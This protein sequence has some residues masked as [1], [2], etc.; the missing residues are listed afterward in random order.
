M[1]QGL[2]GGCFVL[3]L[4]LAGA[5][6]RAEEAPAPFQSLAFD[7]ALKRAA[8]ENKIVFVDFFTTWCGPCQMLDATTWKDPAVAALLREKTVALR[9]DAEKEAALAQ[10]YDVQ[11]YPTMALIKPDGTVIDRL[12]GYRDA[13]KFQSDFADSL[14][15]KTSLARAREEAA[16]AKGDADATAKARY[17]LGQELARAGKND[18]A[19][20]E[21]LWC[22]DDGM[23]KAVGYSGVRLSFLTSS[24][25][26]LGKTYPPALDALRQR[27]DGARQKM[28]KTPSD[29]QAAGDFAALNDAL[30]D[31]QAT[32]DYFDK[33]PPG[34]LRRAA[35]GY[36]LF[37]LLIDAK[38]YAD[39]AAAVPYDQ[40][41][42]TFLRLITPRDGVSAEATAALH[43]YS[44]GY[45]A[46][47]VEVLAGE[48]HADE[49]REMIKTIL[50][51]DR[52]EGAVA[53]LREHL[54]RAGHPELLDAA[55][56]PGPA[57]S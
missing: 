38:R 44:V 31:N 12:V 54:A 49:A 23:V 7:A 24:I 56:A 53:T 2:R 1:K 28:D 15:G 45:G 26:Q 55:P 50:G 21:Y 47:E 29:R 14:A 16:A 13:K 36:R 40:F 30:K 3:L 39:A 25:A 57:K 33:L 19:L 5:V 37:D 52:S 9:V 41:K 32:L 8:K 22:F 6:A 11:A 51:F 42:Q 17:D 43:N 48:G 46:K 34:D 35:M 10:R 18:E 4:C 20:A 27:R